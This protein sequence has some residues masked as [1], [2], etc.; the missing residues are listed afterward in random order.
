MEE[1][2]PS[3]NSFRTVTVRI[4]TDKPVKK[5]PYQVKGVFIKQFADNK[6]IPML[7]G[8]YRK[9]FLYP[10]VQVKILNEQIY[11]VG[12]NEGVD[13]ILSLC[14]KFDVLDFGNITFQI[15]DLDV[16]HQTDI[17]VGV[18]HRCPTRNA[19]GNTLV[20]MSQLPNERALPLNGWFP[21]DGASGAIDFPDTQFRQLT[22]REA[23][24]VGEN[25]SLV[26][27]VNLQGFLEVP[28]VRQIDPRGDT[29]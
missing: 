27:A 21:F 18:S 16:D 10:R 22:A 4:V 7:N 24:G 15:N 26:G 20:E 2:T 17:V 3:S 19:L 12:I 6:I 25:N 8:Q 13:L 28:Q 9:E 23:S 29:T 1:K 11:L 14:K 5:T